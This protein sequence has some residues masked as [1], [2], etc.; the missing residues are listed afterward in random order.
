MLFE[1]ECGGDEHGE[2][3]SEEGEDEHAEGCD[4]HV[5]M[6][7]HNV[8]LWTLFIRD[9]LSE[10]DPNN[11][12]VYAAN[13]A[14]YLEQVA[15]LI[16]ELNS[17]LGALPA[18]NRVLITSHNTFGYLVNPAEFEVVEGVLPGGGTD[19]EPSAADFVD[20]IQLIAETGV[21]AIF[22]ENT[23]P[24]DVVEQ[25]ADET[26]VA[27]YALYTDSLGGPESAAPDYLSFIRY[28]VQTI[29]EALGG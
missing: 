12:Q 2:E 14:A 18:E 1:L 15:A 13:A 6:D 19:A 20:L 5:W 16:P 25:L 9:S 23:T 29:A 4:P 21:P 26:G 28:N 10:L 7:P 17:R 24:S 8:M 11:A 27:V 22:T 3:H